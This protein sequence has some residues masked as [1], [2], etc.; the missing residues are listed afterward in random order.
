MYTQ[1]RFFIRTALANLVAASLVG[2][3]VPPNQALEP[4]GRIGA[5]PPLFYHLLMV[6]WVTQ[7][8][9]G[10]SLW[11]FPPFSRERTRGDERLGWFA[12]GAL[13]GGLLLRAV[14]EPL[15]AWF[16]GAW[17]G[18]MLGPAALLQVLA[19]WAYVAAIWPRV[20]GKR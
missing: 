10:V 2:A 15:H 11:M 12:Y 18:W 13:N 17:F 14:F 19:I 6:G 5:L 3:A 4:D 1:A 20:K 9:C 8:I 16:P 7:L